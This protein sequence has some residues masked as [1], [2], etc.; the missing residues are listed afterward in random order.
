[1]RVSKALVI[2]KNKMASPAVDSSNRSCNSPTEFCEPILQCTAE[3]LFQEVKREAE[4]SGRISD[5][6]MSA[7]LFVFQAPLHQALDLLDRGAVTRYSCPAG[8]E[9]YRVRG[10][11]GRFYICLTSS[12]YCSC[13]SFVYKV[14]VKA[15]SLLCKHMLAVQLTRAIA[16]GKRGCEE[17]TAGEPKYSRLPS[18]EEVCVADEE[19]GRLLV[20]TSSSEQRD[21]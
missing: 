18:V 16:A 17:G 13:P 21:C 5:D 20:S 10:S 2:L 3:Q 19:F 6:L 9:L 12:N 7:L 11:G 8:R 1:M 4:E 15:D 14:L